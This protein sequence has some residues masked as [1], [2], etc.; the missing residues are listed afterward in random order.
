MSFFQHQNSTI[1][2]CHPIHEH[3]WNQTACT[4]TKLNLLG[5]GLTVFQ[6]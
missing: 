6:I 2:I 1:L 3:N 4:R 5:F